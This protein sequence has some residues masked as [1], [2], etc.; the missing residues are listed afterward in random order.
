[1]DVDHR[2]VATKRRRLTPAVMLDVSQACPVGGRN[3]PAMGSSSADLG[4]YWGHVQSWHIPQNDENPAVTGL[5]T[6]AVE[7]SNLRPWD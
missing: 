1:M 6:W 3:S 7:G 2:V 4:T 5:S